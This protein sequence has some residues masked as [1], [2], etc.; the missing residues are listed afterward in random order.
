MN[1][2]IFEPCYNK[3]LRVEKGE[4]FWNKLAVEHSFPTKE[5]RLIVSSKSLMWVV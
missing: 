1:D 3:Y 2:E 4:S 5:K